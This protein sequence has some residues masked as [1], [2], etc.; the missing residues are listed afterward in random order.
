[1]LYVKDNH[2]YISRPGILIEVKPIINGNEVSFDLVGNEISYL[3][4]KVPSEYTRMTTEEIR[5]KL[6]N[7]KIEDEPKMGLLKNKKI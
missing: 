1:M 3:T 6:S 4:D 7:K 5:E 2:Y